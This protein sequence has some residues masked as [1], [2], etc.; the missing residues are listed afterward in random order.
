VCSQQR[1]PVSVGT[2]RDAFLPSLTPLGV[3]DLVGRRDMTQKQF[4]AALKRRG[5]TREH[6][7][8]YVL[9]NGR[10]HVYAANGGSTRRDQLAYLLQEDKKCQQECVS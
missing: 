9:S 5:I 7:G 6:F 1:R 3:N 10:T 8:Y 2:G 4:D